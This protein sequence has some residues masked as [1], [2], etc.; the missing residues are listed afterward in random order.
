MCMLQPERASE[1]LEDILPPTLPFERA[2]INPSHDPDDVIG[3]AGPPPLPHT[4]QQT[5][6]IYGSVS[7]ADMADA[8]K[9]MLADTEGKDIPVTAGDIVILPTMD[10]AGT[11]GDKLKRIG[12]FMIEIQITGGDPVM[13]NIS[14]RPSRQTR[15]QGSEAK[16]RGAGRILEEGRPVESQQSIQP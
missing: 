14:I 6:Q 8:V 16:S 2:L 9:N 3:Q 1:L 15:N 12:E 11:E 4:S 7:T 10:A 13:R 5:S